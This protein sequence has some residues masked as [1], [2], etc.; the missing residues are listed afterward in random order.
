MKKVTKSLSSVLLKV[1]GYMN[2]Y[3]FQL[4]NKMLKTNDYIS[5]LLISYQKK[6][7]VLKDNM[8]RCMYELVEL[9]HYI[10][11]NTGRVK[12]KYFKDFVVKL[13]MLD[14]YTLISYKKKYIDKR[15]RDVIGRF[16]VEIKKISYGVMKNESNSF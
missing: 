3:D 9:I 16:L 2:N 15:R 4:L 14:Y 11:I 5:N 13:S 8:E 12:E 6:E 7:Y 1:Y 10:N